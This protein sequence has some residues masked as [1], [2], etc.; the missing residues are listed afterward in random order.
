MKKNLLIIVCVSL[1][2][3]EFEEF[4]TL[5]PKSF[6][7]ENTQRR[8]SPEQKYLLKTEWAQNG[9]Y[10]PEPTGRPLFTIYNPIP[11]YTPP[12]FHPQFGGCVVHPTDKPSQKTKKNKLECLV[13]PRTFPTLLSLIYHI[14]EHECKYCGNLM[15]KD[16]MEYHLKE[17]PCKK[18]GQYPD[19]ERLSSFLLKKHYPEKGD[20]FTLK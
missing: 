7:S 4:G 19:F 13:C 5:T 1:H 9:C 11:P 6:I 8:L 3:M 14:R 18:T 17:C 10:L 20:F 12:Y 15:S 2:A 16:V